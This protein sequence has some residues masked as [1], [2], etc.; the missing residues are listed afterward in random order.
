MVS[1]PASTVPISAGNGITSPTTRGNTRFW[2]PSTTGKA[3]D[4]PPATPERKE[5]AGSSWKTSAWTPA[6]VA[7]TE[8]PGAATPPP[9]ST[10]KTRLEASKPIRPPG[11]PIGTSHT[12][13]TGTP[14]PSTATV[15]RNHDKATANSTTSCTRHSSDSP[16]QQTQPTQPK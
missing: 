1:K 7:K 2:L 12:A 4:S 9:V 16:E 14:P 15:P 8:T 10:M 6:T 13:T 3:Y 5:T 11:Q